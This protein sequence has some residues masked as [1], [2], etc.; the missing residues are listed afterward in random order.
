MTNKEYE[1]NEAKFHGELAARNAKA[2]VDS[3]KATRDELIVRIQKLEIVAN[4][5][6]QK[7]M[8]LERKY[9]LMLS[10]RFDGK[11]TVRE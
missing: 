5:N 4:Q 11:S 7:I 1:V 3:S 2:A 10:E 8:D 6:I 9:N